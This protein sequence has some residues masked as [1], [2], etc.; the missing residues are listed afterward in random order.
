MIEKNVILEKEAANDG[1]AIYLFYDKR[2]GMY[3]AF[4]WSAFYTTMVVDPLLSYSDELRMPVALIM[5]D[6]IGSLRQS[7]TKVAH[8]E[9]KYYEFKLIRKIGD[10]GYR[11]W[12][13]DNFT[14]CFVNN[15]G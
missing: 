11:K 10:A 8:V 13:K 4:G 2:Y 14:S 3:A 1:Q 9:K 7:L 15:N 6:L 12:M 5:R